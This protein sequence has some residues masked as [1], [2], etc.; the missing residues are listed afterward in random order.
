MRDERLI[1]AKKRIDEL[2]AK[3]SESSMSILNLRQMFEGATQEKMM[4]TNQLQNAQS[5]LTALVAQGRGKSVRIKAKSIENIN[6]YA[7][8]DSKDDDGDLVLTA[9]TVEQV[10]EMQGDLEDHDILED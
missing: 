4:L 5:M 6:K 10:Q 3:L 9:L 8:L 1:K 2:N 7:G